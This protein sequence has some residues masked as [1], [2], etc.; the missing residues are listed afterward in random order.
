MNEIKINEDAITHLANSIE[1]HANNLL[2]GVVVLKNKNNDVFTRYMT[3]VR[4]SPLVD[5]VNMLITISKEC[6]MFG[7]DV[8][9]PFLQTKE[10]EKTAWASFSLEGN[11]FF[12]DEA[13]EKIKEEYLKSKNDVNEFK[14][15]MKKA[16]CGTQIDKKNKN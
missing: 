5:V 6:F 1:N 3:F 7:H 8:N 14:E 12:T 11:P 13:M 16:V 10:A 4:L 9:H 2:D 15:S